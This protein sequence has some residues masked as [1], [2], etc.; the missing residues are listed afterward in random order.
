MIKDKL[1]NQSSLKFDGF[2]DIIELTYLFKSH[3]LREFQISI[4]EFATNYKYIC[5]KILVQFARIIAYQT[6]TDHQFVNT[7]IVLVY[8]FKKKKN[9]GRK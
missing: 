2:F 8:L 1:D 6:R 7:T 4:L 5:T 9:K 3:Q